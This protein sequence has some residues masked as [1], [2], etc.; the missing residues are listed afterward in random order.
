MI[1]A[2]L[3]LN[4]TPEQCAQLRAIQLAYRD[5]CNF[6]SHYAFEN[7]KMSNKVK[8]QDGTYDDI[9]SCFHLPSQMACSVP[10]QVGATY[11]GLWTKVK[12]NAEHRK[13]GRTKKRYKGLD[14]APKFISPTVTYQYK[15]DYSF[16]TEQHVSVLTLDGRV[17]VSYSGYDKHLAL[18]QK[19]AQ[20]GAA[21]L[22]YDKSK[23]HF[24]LLVSLEIETPNPDPENQT[25]C[26]GVDVGV[27]YLTV[28]SN[29]RIKHKFHSGKQVVSRANH[30]ARL[31]KRLQKKGTRPATRRFIAISGRERRLKADANHCV[32]K[33]IVAH[34]P[35]HLIGLEHLTDIR[36]RTKR[37]S[38]KKASKKQRRANATYSK[39][40]FAELQT[41]IAYKAQL[42]GSL[43]IKVDANYTSKACPMC[44]HTCD[45]NRPN[46][47]LLF[48]CQKCHY[49]LHADLVGARNVTMRT[50]LIRQDWVSTGTLSE[51]PDVSDKEAKAARLK[52]FAELRWS[53]DTSPLSLDGGI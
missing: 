21:K 24:Y 40:S 20:I 50:L 33:S 23:K 7:G 38:G 43:A 16:K 36:D 41:M 15:K 2:K 34:Y 51:C 46:K 1:S 42:G 10:R 27:R 48:I 32:S 12:Q 14:Q 29:T 26:A 31:R 11:K 6:V 28:T 45:A 8:L 13:S 35:N 17:V 18:I 39:W 22:W 52:R 5:A 47:G 25:G 3:K 19:G 49:T 9:R 44:G 30:Y 37:R 4:T 53:L